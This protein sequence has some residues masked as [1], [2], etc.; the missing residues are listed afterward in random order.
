[1]KDPRNLWDRFWSQKQIEA[2]YPPVTDIVQELIQFVNPAGKLILEPGAGTGRDGIR[3]AKLGA[4]VFLLDYSEKSLKLAQSYLKT[5]GQEPSVQLVM[6]DALHTPFRDGTFDVVFHQGLLEH[7]RDPNPLLKENYRILKKGGLL[8]IDVPQTFHIYTLIKNILMLFK[9]WF[10][11][12]ERQFT[13]DSLERLLSKYDLEI[14]YYYGDWSRPGIVYKMIRE[15][16]LHLNIRLPMYPR[17]WNWLTRMFY[18]LQNRLKKKRIFLY[19][20]L[21]IGI[22]ARKR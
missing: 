4:R 7:F 10:A 17:Y 11:G 1:M 2:I 19:T 16:F 8:L 21:S 6:A 18:E 14:I 22:I 12:W 5:T 9:L 3:L 13:I 20:V 15:I